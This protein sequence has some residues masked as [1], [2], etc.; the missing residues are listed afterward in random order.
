MKRHED[1]IVRATLASAPRTPRHQRYGEITR[2]DKHV[3]RALALANVVRLLAAAASVLIAGRTACAD[4]ALTIATA[5]GPRQVLV[6]P[7]SKPG[8]NPTLIVLHGTVVSVARLIR[9]GGFAEAAAIYGFS[10]VFPEGKQQ[11][12]NDASGG[13]HAK[14][15]DIGFL[16]ALA[17]RLVDA[18]I[19]DP[20]RLYLAG[21]SNGGML[22]FAMICRPQAMFA[23]VAAIIANMP[24]DLSHSCAPPK[25]LTVVLM[26]GTADPIMPFAGGHVGFFRRRGNVLSATM[27]AEIFAK[28]EGCG[29]AAPQVRLPKRDAGERT[30]VTLK[31]WSGCAPR[32]SVRLYEVEG[33]GHQIPGGPTFL[34]FLF[35]SPNH[36]IAAAQVILQA[37]AEAKK[38]L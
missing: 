37:F 25:P 1:A 30:H 34:P 22:A 11:P 32:A 27:T 2:L 5:D 6:L 28:A 13:G 35:G 8:P 7:A 4:E 15:D 14:N 18:K 23:G 10:V 36:D 20:A 21:I 19:A 17:H 16:N 9:S 29:A 26:N 31:I 3:R 33:G 24:A 38:T 12:W